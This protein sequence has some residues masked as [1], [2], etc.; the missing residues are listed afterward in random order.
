MKENVKMRE[1]S[2]GTKKEHK[3]LQQQQSY[4]EIPSWQSLAVFLSIGLRELGSIHLGLAAGARARSY[5]QTPYSDSGCG[6]WRDN[7]TSPGLVSLNLEYNL[8]GAAVSSSIK[9]R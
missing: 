3:M 5:G 9:W 4:E 6:L 2:V 8:I 1:A 7:L